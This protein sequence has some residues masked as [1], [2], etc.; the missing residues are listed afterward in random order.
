MST[1]SQSSD[2]ILESHLLAKLDVS[3]L[4]LIEP[5][6]KKL[7]RNNYTKNI[8]M[9]LKSSNS[10]TGSYK[11]TLTGWYAIKI[12]VF[13]Q[14]SVMPGNF[15]GI[16]NQMNHSVYFDLISP[17]DIVCLFHWSWIYDIVH[18]PT[19]RFEFMMAQ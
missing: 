11:I 3:Y 5:K 6:A 19:Q 1:L 12:N 14:V 16:L 2:A 8:I 13:L 9:N 7:L 10:L 15:L 4:C 18:Y 17:F